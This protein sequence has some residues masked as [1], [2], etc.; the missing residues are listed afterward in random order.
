MLWILYLTTKWVI[1]VQDMATMQL[2]EI[3]NGRLAMLGIS[4]M[5][6][7]RVVQQT[8][9]ANFTLLV[10]IRKL[11]Q[12]YLRPTDLNFFVALCRN[13]SRILPYWQG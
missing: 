13:G 3:K 8:L 11:S 1:V 10:F 7:K 2:K 5:Y 6:E 12:V 4:G 9:F